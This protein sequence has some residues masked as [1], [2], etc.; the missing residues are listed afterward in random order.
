MSEREPKSKNRKDNQSAP[1]RYLLDTSAILAYTDEE[2]GA[3]EV[4]QLLTLA[5]EGKCYLEICAFSLMEIYYVTLRTSDEDEAAQLVGL[6]KAWPVTWIYPN[7]KLL[8]QAGKLKAAYRLSVADALIAA[9]AKLRR[10]TLVHKDPELD[11]LSHEVALHNLPFKKRRRALEP[12]YTRAI[13]A[14]LYFPL[15]GVKEPG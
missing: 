12:A 13:G 5:Q 10:A 9:A 3:E 8:L 1:E 7:E 14:P 11:A 2:E 4:K 15:V 6:V